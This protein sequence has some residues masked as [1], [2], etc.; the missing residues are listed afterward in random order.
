[1]TRSTNRFRRFW[2][3][4]HDD[5]V[6]AR[7]SRG[8]ARLRALRG[9]V[10]RLRAEHRPRCRQPESRISGVSSLTPW[11]GVSLIRFSE[12]SP[13]I[14]ASGCPARWHFVNVQA[15]LSIVAGMFAHLSGPSLPGSLSPAILPEHH[16]RRYACLAGTFIGPFLTSPGLTNVLLAG[17]LTGFLPCGLV[18]GFLTLASSTASIIQG[19]LTMIAFG[20]VPHRS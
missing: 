19:P 16:R 2:K 13:V 20:T 10:R 7:V 4:V 12:C 5:R 15:G 11:A 1:M 6:A 9:H 17:I 3:P 14:A 18:Y 8:I